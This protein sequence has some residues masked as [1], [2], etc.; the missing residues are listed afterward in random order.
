MTG[1]RLAGIETSMS[2]D[3]EIRA[4]TQQV[5]DVVTRAY[6]LSRHLDL[7]LKDL[8]TYGP[9]HARLADE[10]RATATVWRE[11]PRERRHD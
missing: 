4:L 9:R 1:V 7:A 11:A 5:R 10:R 8:Q 2:R 6:T 3:P